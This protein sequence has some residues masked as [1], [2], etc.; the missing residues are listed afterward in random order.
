MRKLILIMTGLVLVIVVGS[1]LKYSERMRDLGSSWQAK[2]IK[3]DEKYN[4]LEAEKDKKI[5]ALEESPYPHRD[6]VITVVIAYPT[7]L[8]NGMLA[9]RPRQVA[10]L[11]KQGSFG[12]MSTYK[13]EAF[14]TREEYDEIM[15][16]LREELMERAEKGNEWQRPRSN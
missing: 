12:T 14:S 9:M 16:E 13:K 7:I 4:V 15:K 3:W 5:K 11:L 10:I 6:I 1:T 2:Q 8:E